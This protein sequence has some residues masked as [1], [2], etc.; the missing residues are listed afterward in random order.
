MPGYQ[1]LTIVGHVG[2]DCEL[3][4]SQSGTAIASFSVAVT[5]HWTDKNTNERR[6]KTT[7]FRVS[8]FRSLAETCQQFVHKGMQVMI[9]GEIDAS[10]YE[11]DGEPRAS[12]EL[13]ASE[14]VFLG[15]RDEA[16]TEGA[17]KT[18]DLPF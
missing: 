3:K 1:Q 5:K 6:E 15:R 11:K 10:A 18:E 12:L 17:G 2:R 13:T 9:V 16:E 8:A 7:W 4:Y 14:V